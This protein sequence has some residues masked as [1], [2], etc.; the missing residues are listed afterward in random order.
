MDVLKRIINSKLE[1]HFKVKFR[2]FEDAIVEY[3]NYQNV[4]HNQIKLNWREIGLA[5]GMQPKQ[6]RNAFE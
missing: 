3:R 2:C 6:A 1:D 4:K 5:M